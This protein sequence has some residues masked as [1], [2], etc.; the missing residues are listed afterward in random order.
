MSIDNNVVFVSQINPLADNP[1]FDDVY[2]IG[3]FCKIDRKMRR[4][5]AGTVNLLSW[6]KKSTLR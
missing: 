2:H 4:D 3:T 6:S 5:S 1:K